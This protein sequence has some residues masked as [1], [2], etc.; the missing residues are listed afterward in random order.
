[1]RL[2][3]G[4]A[5]YI[6]WKRANGCKYNGGEALLRSFLRR[7]G[8]LE[9]ND[10]S[11]EI[12]SAHLDAY[13]PSGPITWR[14]KY[15]LL[16]RFF[17][18]WAL[19]GSMMSLTMPTLRATSP[20][21]HVPQI[22]SRE[23]IRSL[24]R[25]AFLLRERYPDSTSAQT[26][27][28]LMLLLYG[29]GARV[30]E[31]LALRVSEVDFV[32]G[33]IVLRANRYNSVRTIP[34]CRDLVVALRRYDRWRNR[35]HPQ[36]D[37]FF[38]KNDGTA[39]SRSSV[40]GLFGRICELAS[41]RR[42]DGAASAMR[43]FRPTFAVHRISSWLRTSSDLSRLLPALAVYMGHI[44]LCSA[45]KYLFMTPERFRKALHKLTPVRRRGHWREDHELMIFLTSLR[46]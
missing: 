10:I 38:V 26:M 17:D 15:Q 44:N 14:G 4:I 45:Q 5:G 25:S 18:F 30:G 35:H 46:P 29:T 7:T 34:V 39:L 28:M 24:M 1:M 16:Q 43:D 31:A 13:P 41:V 22:F 23:Q 42:L 27:R 6:D 19:R 12:V 20:Q 33:V 36:C 40:K 2:S 37:H 11:P 9:L 32:R 8:D 3:E 21:T